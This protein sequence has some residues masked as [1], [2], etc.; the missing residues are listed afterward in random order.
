MKITNKSEFETL[1]YLKNHLSIYAGSDLSG[2][3]IIS[4][5]FSDFF[6]NSIPSDF[7]LQFIKEIDK[8][9]LKK[10]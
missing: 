9:I 7:S 1:Y 3:E 10:G 8:I 2:D 5:V 4:E 6:N